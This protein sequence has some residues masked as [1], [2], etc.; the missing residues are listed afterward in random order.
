MQ[1]IPETKQQNEIIK[2]LQGKFDSMMKL[3]VFEINLC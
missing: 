1:A 2:M 3:N